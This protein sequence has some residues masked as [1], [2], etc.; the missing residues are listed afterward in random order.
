LAQDVR[1]M[2]PSPQHNYDHFVLISSYTVSP[3]SRKIMES[4]LQQLELGLYHFVV[5][6]VHIVWILLKEPCLLL[7][8]LQ[9]V[10]DTL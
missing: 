3:L 10:L 4:A 9:I 2:N 1:R 5:L 8:H 6:L 7:S